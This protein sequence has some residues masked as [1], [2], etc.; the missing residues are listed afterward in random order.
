MRTI[1]CDVYGTVFDNKSHFERLFE[2]YF[3]EI[4]KRLQSDWKAIYTELVFVASHH[5][6]C[7]SYF[8]MIE[9][10]LVASF[11]KNS[12]SF[13][14][15]IIDGILDGYHY[16]PVHSD[17]LSW[18][19]E[20]LRIVLYSNGSQNMLDRL[21]KSSGIFENI[22]F[23]S[24]EKSGRLKPSPIAYSFMRN[25][26]GDESNLEFISSNRWDILGANMFGI[27]TIWINRFG[28]EFFSGKYP[29]SRTV[30]SFE[31]IHA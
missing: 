14:S 19:K 16:I 17:F 27:K 7:Y 30:K 22:E 6:A 18:N 1:V 21:K 13:D 4:G 9:N 25:W 5:N 8:E 23:L 2:K 29:P 26:I 31:E 20:E 15:K 12:V 28:E 24:S 11:R 3:P 10:A